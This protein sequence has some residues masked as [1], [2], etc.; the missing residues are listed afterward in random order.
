M[1]GPQALQSSRHKSQ[2]RSARIGHTSP[3]YA[4]AGA[5]VTHVCPHDVVLRECEGVPEAVVHVRLRRE[6]HD[7][8]DLLGAQHVLHE[9]GR[10][11]VPFR[12]Q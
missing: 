4:K 2:C 9:V 6:V 12:I 1:S 5:S 7:G 8:I 3:P 10:A 11:D